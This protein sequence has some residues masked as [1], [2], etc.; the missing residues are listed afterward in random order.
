[1]AL[2]ETLENVRVLTHSAI[3]IQSENGT[4][5]Y[6]DPYDLVEEPHDA[7]VVLITH[8]HYDH[9]SPEDYVRVAKPET[10][11]VAPASL[12][13]EVA[14]LNASEIVLLT[15]G[16]SAE[17]CGIKIEA[18]PAYNVEPERL[19]FHPKDNAWVGYILTIDGATYYIAGDTDQNEETEKVR[20]DVALIPIGGTYTMDARQAAAFINNMKPRFVVPT[21]Y[22][23]AVGTKEDVEVF[24][25]LVDDEITV[26][27]KMEWH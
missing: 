20:C 2:T 18:V 17:V 7:D 11:I 10:I 9:L 19:Q 5:V 23:T 8:G 22:G 3:R 16:E 12:K 13:G 6:A 27:R 1:M 15:A 26:I 24:E 4:V 21:H 14:A 25:P